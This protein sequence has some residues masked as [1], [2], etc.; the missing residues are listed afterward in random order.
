MEYIDYY[1]E[2]GKLL[3]KET[4]EIIHQDALWHK[5][6]HC[7]L[8]N[9]KGEVF[10]QIRKDRGTLYTTASGHLVSG[11]TISEGFQREI[12]EEIG[13][14][15]N[16]DKSTFIEVVP[17]IMDMVKKDGTV[18]KD[19]A[20]SNVYANLYQ[21]NYK[22]FKMDLEEL[23]GLVLVNA[24]EALSLFEKGKGIILGKVINTKNE[25]IEREIDFK[26]FL[27]NQDETALS[28]YGK[29]MAKIVELTK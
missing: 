17:F 4:R 27:V 6:V 29:I 28:K 1:D 25:M 26:E 10:F 3:G 24:K 20:W 18:F 5:T 19:R 16:K 14:L 12:H 9:E 13:I 15:V 21:G 11:E 23:D 7:W 2:D 8:Y 22:D